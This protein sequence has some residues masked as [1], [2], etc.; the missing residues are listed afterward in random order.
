[1][2]FNLNRHN[3]PDYQ[4]KNNQINELIS[5]Y[6]VECD[7]LY[8]EKVNKDSVFKDFSHLKFKEGN[9]KKVVLLPENPDGF[10]GSYN[11]NLFGLQNNLVVNFFISH[12]S[13]LD[14]LS[15]KEK[16]VKEVYSF[17]TNKLL[18][19][20][21]GIILEITDVSSIIEGVNNLF[22]YND[23]KSAYK[24]STRVYYNS[25]QNEME[26]DS[27][28]KDNPEELKQNQPQDE[29]EAPKINYQEESPTD[30]YEQSFEDLDEYFKSLDEEN[31]Y[32]QEENRI[33]SGIDNVFGKLG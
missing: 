5:M 30:N 2:A 1:M 21:N 28:K 23:I 20:P 25:K 19:L 33:S 17:F 10:D 6:G 16:E 3:H 11:W 18:V 8:V 15:Q 13:V 12:Q 24:L 26:Y 9:S 4:L 22:L 29:S 7:F 31:E 27:N 32:I 14:V